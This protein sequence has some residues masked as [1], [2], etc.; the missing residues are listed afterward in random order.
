MSA[1]AGGEH[2]A[3]NDAS[4]TAPPLDDETRERLLNTPAPEDRPVYERRGTPPGATS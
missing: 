3:E 4:R 2:F 1:R